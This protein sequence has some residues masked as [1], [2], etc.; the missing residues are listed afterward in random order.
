MT[1]VDPY[2]LSTILNTEISK[3]TV[4]DWAYYY[5]C[6]IGSENQVSVGRWS[7]LSKITAQK[8]SNP[9]SSITLG[10]LSTHSSVTET[11]KVI[12]RKVKGPGFDLSITNKRKSQMEMLSN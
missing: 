7:N 2:A 11:R 1:A 6:F 9:R 5:L 4:Q 10:P 8:K 12:S 3:V